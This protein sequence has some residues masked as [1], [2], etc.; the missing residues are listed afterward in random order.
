MEVRPDG[1]RTRPE[2]PLLTLNRRAALLDDVG[3]LASVHEVH[4]GPRRPLQFD[5]L[6]RREFVHCF[7]MSAYYKAARFPVPPRCPA[8]E[9][10]TS[11][12]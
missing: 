3:E 10:V 1:R 7:S 11:Y 2:P 5:H 4:F 8:G 9:F 6:K 12:G